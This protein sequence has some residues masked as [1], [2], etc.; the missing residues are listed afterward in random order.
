MWERACVSHK[1]GSHLGA[2]FLF[3]QLGYIFG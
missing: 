3:K 1:K 2:L